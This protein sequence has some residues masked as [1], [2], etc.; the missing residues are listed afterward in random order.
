M[1][2]GVSVGLRVAVG[3]GVIVAVVVGVA[4]S[5]TIGAFVLVSLALRLGRGVSVTPGA[6]W[7]VRG[8]LHAKLASSSRI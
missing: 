3:E 5:V 8:K 4:V 2:V 7:R 6:V 1:G